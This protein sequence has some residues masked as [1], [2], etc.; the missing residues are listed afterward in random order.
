MLDCGGGALRAIVYTKNNVTL[1]KNVSQPKRKGNIIFIANGSRKKNI[2]RVF[3]ELNCL[4]I[5]YKRNTESSNKT[6]K[7]KG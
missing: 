1:I 5:K 7:I 6:R 3:S 4:Y 2:C